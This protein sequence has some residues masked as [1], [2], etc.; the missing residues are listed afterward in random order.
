MLFSYAKMEQSAAC[1]MGFTSG[2]YIMRRGLG[3]AQFRK[4]ETVA[5]RSDRNYS[6]VIRQPSVAAKNLFLSYPKVDALRGF[7]PISQP[8]LILLRQADAT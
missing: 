8:A 3:R 2:G 6:N 4:L 1:D 5:S 7:G